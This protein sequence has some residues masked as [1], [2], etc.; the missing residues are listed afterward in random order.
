MTD[1]GRSGSS[2]GRGPTACSTSRRAVRCR[3]APSRRAASSHACRRSADADR[4]LAGP[5]PHRVRRPPRLSLTSPSS[6]PTARA[7]AT[8]DLPSRAACGS[9]PRTRTASGTSPD[10]LADDPGG[11]AGDPPGGTALL[12][13]DRRGPLPWPSTEMSRSRGAPAPRRPAPGTRGRRASSARRRRR[14]R[15]SARGANLMAVTMPRRCTDRYAHPVTS[16]D[17]VRRAGRPAHLRQLPPARRSCSTPSTSSPTRRPTTSC[18]SSP[19]TRST[20]CG[21]SSCCTRR[22][23]ARDAMLGGGRGLWWAQHLLQ[24]MHVIE[25]VLVQQVDVLETMTPQDFLAVPA[26]AGA[27]ERLPVGAVPRA[28]V[29]L[30]RQG[31]V[32]RRAV[33]RAD[34]RR[35]GAAAAAAGRAD[36]VGRVP[37]RAR[38]AAGCRSATTTRSPTRVRRAAHDRSTYA[39]VWALAEALLAARRARRR[40]AGPARGDG[41]ADDRHQDRHRW[42]VGRELPAQPAATCATTRCSGSCAR[43]SE[44]APARPDRPVGDART[45]LVSGRRHN[46]VRRL[47]ATTRPMLRGSTTLDATC[48]RR[49]RRPDRARPPPSPPAARAPAARPASGPPSC[50]AYFYRHVAAEDLVDRSEV[51]LYGAAMSHYKLAADRPQGT[52]NVRVF[53]PTVAEH[54]WSAGG[55]TVVEVVTD[56]MPFLVDSVTM[57]LNEQQPRRAHGR[58]TRSSL[59]RR[60]I[61]GAARARSFTDDAAAERRRCRTTSSASRGCTSRST[62]SPSP[63]SVEEIEQALRKVLRDVREAVEDWAEDA[64]RRRCAIVEDLDE[65]PAAAARPR[66]SRE[67]QALLRLAGRRPLH[68]PRLPRVPPRARG[69]RRR[70]ACAPSPAPASASCAP[71]RTCRR[72]SASCRRWSR[73]RPARRPCWCWPRPT[74]RPTVHRPAYLDY[75]GVKTFDEHGEV[76]GERRFLGLFSSRRL[77]RVADPDPGAAREGRSRC[78]E[79]RRLRPAQPRRQ[80]ADGHPRDLPARRAVPD[81]GRRAGADRR[82][83]AAHPRA[84]PAAAVRPPRHLRPLPVL[85]GLPAPRPLHHRRPRADRRDP[86]ATELGGESHRVHRPGQRVAAGPAAL[87][88]PPDAGR[89]DRRRRRR[90]TSSAGWPR[91]PAPGATTSSP[92]RI[93]EYGEEDGAAA[94]P[95]ATPTR[96]PRPT[97]RTTRRAPARSTSA[98]SRRIEGDGGLDLSLYAADRRRP[99][100]RRG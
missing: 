78:I 89:A 50:C 27:G 14:R 38:R 5:G 37:G 34:R 8:L 18:C 73:P 33:P 51:D 77:H 72:R 93:A 24:R 84:P 74:R 35:A 64:R 48:E 90:P 4:G 98:G 42:V 30:R 68:V 70:R 25:R 7:A 58:C 23:A 41:R 87:R 85:P 94:G 56:D 71:T 39:E 83:G 26:A 22:A 19:S 32:V 21:S 95:H 12:H 81:P 29:P 10:L 75:V 67:G 16:P 76:V 3:R 92:P 66:R 99:A 17:L 91:R 31:P 1:A 65:R 57:E 2:A 9:R 63:T 28:G 11:E 54:G 60:D 79:P 49:T 59:V 36:A 40:L 62:G 69:R 55:H 96:S 43:C 47:R 53:T 45:G 82:G 88:R 15:R 52:A 13:D 61:T 46:D 97:R 80:G 86:Q 6:R 20:S 100:A 44:P